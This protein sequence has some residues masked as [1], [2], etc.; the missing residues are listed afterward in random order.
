MDCNGSEGAPGLR[1]PN[2]FGSM[3]E[4]EY[5]MKNL[6][7][8][9]VKTFAGLVMFQGLT[10]MGLNH[11]AASRPAAKTLTLAGMDMPTAMKISET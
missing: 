7:V 10:L 3:K 1:G 4:Q 9:L 6:A 5:D 8:F 11:C 2:D